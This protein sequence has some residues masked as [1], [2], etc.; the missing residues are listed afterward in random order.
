MAGLI[1]VGV[2]GS[3]PSR[4][5]LAWAVEEAELR[6]A[7][8]AAIH[9]WVFVPPGPL[10]EPGMMPAAGVDF[11][12]ML[13]AEEDAARAELESALEA[14]FPD[15]IPERVE[16]KLVDGDPA[17]VLEAEAADADLAVVG[18]RGRSALASAL[19]GSVSRHLV[20]NARCPV[21]VV[22]AEP[23]G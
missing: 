17:Q 3:E 6:D 9:A 13:K 22:K 10:A 15:G 5:A 18:S 19:L 2:D 12:R 14:A 16:P 4:A 11:A 1:V 8:V 21:V 7:R 23:E 20:H